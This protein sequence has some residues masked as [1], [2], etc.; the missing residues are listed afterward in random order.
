[1]EQLRGSWSLVSFTRL[2]A[3]GAVT[4]PYGEGATGCIIYGTDDVVSYQLCGAPRAGFA[5]GDF[6]AATPEELAAAARSFRSYVADASVEGNV[7]SHR[8]F[9][10]FHQDRVGE[11][12]RRTFEFRDGGAMLVLR[13]VGGSEELVWRRRVVATG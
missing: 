1:M 4:H 10:S 5:S 12:L 9:L 13:P 2:D 6:L 11:V 7:V 3:A 8:V